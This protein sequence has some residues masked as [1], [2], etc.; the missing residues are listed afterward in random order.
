[1]LTSAEGDMAGYGDDRY[2]STISKVVLEGDVGEILLGAVYT[3]TIA[4]DHLNS[5]VPCFVGCDHE[6]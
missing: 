5:N 4:N 1:M 2:A 3:K 6:K